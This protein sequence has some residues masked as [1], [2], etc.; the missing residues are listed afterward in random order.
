MRS[1]WLS[2]VS[3]DRPAVCAANE[4]DDPEVAPSSG[5]FILPAPAVLPPPFSATFSS[6]SSF[7]LPLSVSLFFSGVNHESR[8]CVVDGPFSSVVPRCRERKGERWGIDLRASG[9]RTIGPSLKPLWS[10]NTFPAA[11]QCR[12][13][14][15]EKRNKLKNS[16]AFYCSISLHLQLIVDSPEGRNDEGGEEEE[17]ARPWHFEV[18]V[19]RLAARAGTPKTLNLPCTER[20]WANHTHTQGLEPWHP[21]GHGF[22]SDTRTPEGMLNFLCMSTQPNPI[23]SPTTIHPQTSE[24]GPG[25]IVCSLRWI[26]AFKFD[27]FTEKMDRAEDLAWCQHGNYMSGQWHHQ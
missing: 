15:G 18:P 3:I 13:E 2:C 21:R 23:A 11:S 26:K 8:S 17:E 7:L 20:L 4:S 16:F 25:S 1:I 5:V 19:D 22:K 27:W 9:R 6:P 10:T 12:R 24:F 14:T